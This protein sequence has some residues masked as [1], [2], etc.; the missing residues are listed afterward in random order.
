MSAIRSSV[1]TLICAAVLAAGCGSDSTAPKASIAGTWSL[2]TINGTPLPFTIQA[3]GANKEEVTA[4][5]VTLTND[6]SFT[7][8]ASLRFTINGAVTTQ[9]VPDAGRYTLN[10]TAVVVT[11]NS[12]GTSA[13]GSWDG[14][15]TIT[16][17]DQGFA[18]VYRRQ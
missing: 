15:N 13:T 9:S 14:S 12:D 7:E 18:E 4:D 16:I 17:A 3:Q 6:G 5:I 8:L 1:P 11:F 10:G 2:Q